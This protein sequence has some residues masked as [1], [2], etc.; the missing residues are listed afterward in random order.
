MHKRITFRGMEHSQ[1]M[2]DH[3]N[4]MLARIEHILEEDRSPRYIDL[5]L[6]P[7]KVHAHHHVE[8]RVKSP[9]YDRVVDYEGSDFYAVLDHV[10]DTMYRML[11]EDKDRHIEDRK[12]LG[13]HEEFKKQR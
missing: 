7:S 11:L 13:R 1:P 8:L 4:D 2:E 12:M 6:Q 10:L 3:A 9:S 5:V